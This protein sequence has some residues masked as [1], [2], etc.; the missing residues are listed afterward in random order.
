MDVVTPKPGILRCHLY[1]ESLKVI[2]GRLESG[3][4]GI[5]LP[6]SPLHTTWHTFHYVVTGTMG[7][8][9][10][11]EGIQLVGGEGSET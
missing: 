9:V 2:T 4:R 1:D 5:R 7:G 3:E 8:W 11:S 6:L 10:E